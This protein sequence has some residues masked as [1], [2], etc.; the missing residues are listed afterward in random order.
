[1]SGPCPGSDAP[2]PA[3]ARLGQ[4]PSPSAADPVWRWSTRPTRRPAGSGSAIRSQG[5]VGRRAMKRNCRFARNRLRQ[6]GLSPSGGPAPRTS[7]SMQPLVPSR[8]ARGPPTA[9]SPNAGA[10]PG[11]DGQAIAAPASV[12]AKRSVRPDRRPFGCT[13]PGVWEPSRIKPASESR[14]A[15]PSSFAPFRPHRS[16][17]TAGVPARFDPGSRFAATTETRAACQPRARSGRVR[18]AQTE[19]ARTDRGWYRAASRREAKTSH[20]LTAISVSRR[21]SSIA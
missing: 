13:K 8:T 18:Q 10:R 15:G 4:V 5:C 7:G 1:M 17:P 16:P 21:C 3:R 11:R 14:L 12:F 19:R 20:P 9:Q 6:V 2:L